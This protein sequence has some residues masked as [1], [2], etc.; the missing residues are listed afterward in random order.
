[1]STSTAVFPPTKTC[2]VDIVLKP[3]TD[4]DADA[5]E[6]RHTDIVFTEFADRYL[7]VVTQ[8]RKIGGVVSF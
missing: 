4:T 1:M 7:A 2:G 6:T 8:Y 5:P 3:S